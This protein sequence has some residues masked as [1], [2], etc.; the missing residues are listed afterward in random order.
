MIKESH[1]KAKQEALEAEMERQRQL[2]EER[3]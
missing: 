1:E 2:E 3:K